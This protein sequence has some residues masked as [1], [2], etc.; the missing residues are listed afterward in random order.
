MYEVYFKKH[1]RMFFVT[2]DGSDT[3]ILHACR[4][5]KN[6]TEKK[7]SK[8]IIKRAKELGE[9]LGKKIY[10]GGEKMAFVKGNVSEIIE[11]KRQND[12]EFKKI[13]DESREEYRLIGEMIKIRKKERITQS[14]LAN[15]IGS[16]QQVVSRIEKHESIPSLQFF[17]KML[18]SLGYEI[19]ITKKTI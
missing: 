10:I 9:I 2:V 11:E 3:Y 16:K 4:K 1:N 17:C 19:Q 6:K 8:I 7:D 18:D 5:Q 14:K 12:P 15:L 13:R